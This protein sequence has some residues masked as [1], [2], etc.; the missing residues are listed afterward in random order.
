VVDTV[1]QPK[2]ILK[3]GEEVILPAEFMVEG[4][5]IERSIPAVQIEGRDG[6]IPDIDAATYKPRDISIRGVIYK[7]TPEELEE[8]FRLLVS[9]FYSTV[10][11]YQTATSDKYINVNCT[12]VAHSFVPM[13]RQTAAEISA[14]FRASDPC[15]YGNEVTLTTNIT[16]A[17]V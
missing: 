4:W 3:N 8:Q 11:L 17:G 16:E 7:D 10:K 5:P 15:F 13:S 1:P 2:I 14:I 12:T 9:Q 6:E